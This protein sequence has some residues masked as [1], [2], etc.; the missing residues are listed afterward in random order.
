MS[1]S[2]REFLDFLKATCAVAALP[3]SVTAQQSSNAG[4]SISHGKAKRVKLH[5]DSEATKKEV[6][7]RI[8]IRR[9]I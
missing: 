7:K 6:L 1:I 3:A 9:S 4:Q 5:N 2:R 8:P